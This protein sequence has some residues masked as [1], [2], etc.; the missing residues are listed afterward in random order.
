MKFEIEC[1]TNFDSGHICPICLTNKDMPC[2]LM[3]I[4]GTKNGNIVECEL[5]HVK[6]L[7][8]K[9]ANKDFV[10]YPELHA[11]AL[12]LPEKEK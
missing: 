12:R 2:V 10:Y 1:F 9:L 3:R 5:F 6:C 4:Y 11:I 8:D 7:I